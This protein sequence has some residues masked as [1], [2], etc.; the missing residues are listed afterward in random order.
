MEVRN[1]DHYSWQLLLVININDTDVMLIV[2]PSN[3]QHV[4]FQWLSRHFQ[5]ILSMN[6]KATRREQIIVQPES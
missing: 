1:S 3:R 6:I 2:S 5:S 4:P